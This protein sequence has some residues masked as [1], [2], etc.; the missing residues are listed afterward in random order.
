MSSTSIR[1]RRKELRD[2]G[3]R[4]LDEKIAAARTAIVET[5][6]PDKEAKIDAIE[7]KLGDLEEKL[8]KLEAQK[9]K[10]ESFDKKA[11]SP[12][13]KIMQEIAAVESKIKS[14]EAELK[15]LKSG[16]AS[17]PAVRVNEAEEKMGRKFTI[18]LDIQERQ[19]DLKQLQQAKRQLEQQFAREMAGMNAS[20]KEAEEDIAQL[21][22]ALKE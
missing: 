9:E 13:D 17:L 19:D 2:F 10:Q 4:I 15:R 18:R 6:A 7:E 5:R 12:S 21:K 14:L 16:R 22:M 3:N 11:A 1:D 20:I 8:M